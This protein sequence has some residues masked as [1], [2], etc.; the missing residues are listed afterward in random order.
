MGPLLSS[1]PWTS[2]LDSQRQGRGG[3]RT[4]PR[5]RLLRSVRGQVRRDEASKIWEGG[6]LL[7]CSLR[8]GFGRPTH[9]T[10]ELHGLFHDRGLHLGAHEQHCCKG[11]ERLGLPAH[12]QLLATPEDGLGDVPL[13]CF[14]SHDRGGKR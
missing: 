13:Q 1:A 4:I 8:P 11:P 14:R 12:L 5:K 2:P 7:R 6:G 10:E 9:L 3:P